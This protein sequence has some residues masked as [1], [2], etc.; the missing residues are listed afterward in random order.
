MLNVADLGEIMGFATCRRSE[1]QQQLHSRH[2]HVIGWWDADV[3]AGFAIYD[4][5]HSCLR[6]LH[7]EVREDYRREYIA[8][9]LI[10]Y[11]KDRL[12]WRRD[13][14]T[15]VVGKDV[16]DAHACL[17]NNGLLKKAMLGDFNIYEWKIPVEQAIKEYSF[18]YNNY[19]GVGKAVHNRIAKHFKFK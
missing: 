11:I 18:K 1:V 9:D 5:T 6:L 15:A 4:L 14:V 19:G 7:I 17:E 12:G 2:S 8:S 16:S 10:S 13:K 3:L